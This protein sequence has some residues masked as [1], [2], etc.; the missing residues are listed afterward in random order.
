MFVFH[1]VTEM[2]RALHAA[3]R[4]ATGGA[5]KT[6]SRPGPE[7]VEQRRKRAG[8]N[9]HSFGRGNKF[10]QGGMGLRHDRITDGRK[11]T[12]SYVIR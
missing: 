8:N 9:S 12:Q 4:L 5:E 11:Q 6:R 3:M 2:E 10:L 1:T 7:D